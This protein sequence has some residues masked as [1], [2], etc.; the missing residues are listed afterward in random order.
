MDRHNNEIGLAIGKNAETWEDVKA[1]AQRIIDSSARDGSG[2]GGGAVWR[3]DS[4]WKGNPKDEQGNEIPNENTNWPNTDWINGR[5]EEPYDYPYGGPV[6][7]TGPFGPLDVPA[8]TWSQADVEEV[9][10]SAAYRNDWHP[11]SAVAREKVTAW[12]SCVYG[13]DPVKRDATGR[14]VEP[15]MKRQPGPGAGAVQARAYTREGDERVR[16]H[17]RSRP[18]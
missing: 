12:F 7:D 2:S 17:T 4:D 5:V 15:K 10:A 11:Q 3:P 6:D 13:D 14:M 18:G 1:E 9:M 16:A 8:E